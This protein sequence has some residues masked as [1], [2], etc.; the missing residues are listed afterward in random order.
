MTEFQILPSERHRLY[1][2]IGL[3]LIDDFL[4]SEPIG[5]ITP[6]LDLLDGSG[7]WQETEI[8]AVKNLSGIFTYP[9]LG[10]RGQL[11]GQPVLKYRVRI[12]SKYY[13]PFYR[14]N[15]DGIEFDVFPYNHSHPPQNIPSIPRTEVLL[16]AP[17]YPYSSHL[18]VLRG[19][20]EDS[21]GNRILD[22]LV[23]EGNR[24]RVIT[25]GRGEFVLPLRWPNKVGPIVIDAVNQKTGE[26]G[27]IS[28]SLPN[29]LGK[30][31]KITIS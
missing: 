5:R 27:Q 29:D 8:K 19:F 16:P 13:Y 2:S 25:D 4:G 7:L 31:H 15:S 14:L 17:N 28:V 23:T 21:T 22:T 11:A 18:R 30:G 20:V 24:E 3:R 10:L 9:A 12:K 26:T 6:F 1:S